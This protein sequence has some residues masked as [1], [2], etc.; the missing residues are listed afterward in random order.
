MGRGT[1][2]HTTLAKKGTLCVWISHEGRMTKCWDVTNWNE[3]GLPLVKIRARSKF[4]VSLQEV[5]EKQCNVL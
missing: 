3:N 1:H 4:K 2:T 5:T